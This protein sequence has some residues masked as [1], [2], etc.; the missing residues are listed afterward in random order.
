MAEDLKSVARRNWLLRALSGMIALTGAVILYPAVRFLMPRAAT[1]SGAVEKVAPFPLS[2]LKPDAEG[3]WPSP[4]NFGG[5]PCLVIRTPDGTVRAFNAICTHLDCTIAYRPDE[6]DIFC[7][8]HNG[9][10][11]LNGRVVSGPPP[12]P[13]EEYKV[14]LRGPR[15]EEIVVSRTS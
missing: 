3:N 11:D 2:E 12:G 8:C 9:V 4:F 6:S 5:K 1:S 14:D 15:K 13:L 10:Y 7:P